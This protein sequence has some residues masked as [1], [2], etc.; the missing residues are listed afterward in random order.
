M[1]LIKTF[2]SILFFLFYSILICS[3]LLFLKKTSLFFHIFSLHAGVRVVRSARRARAPSAWSGSAPSVVQRARSAPAR[4]RRP[5]PALRHANT[6]T[7]VTNATGLNAVGFFISCGSLK[8]LPACSSSQHV[9]RRAG[10]RL[11]HRGRLAHLGRLRSRR[12]SLR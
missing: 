11:R 9:G 6:P 10:E 8:L 7:G 4:R 12:Q 3:I 1:G 2:C 5:S